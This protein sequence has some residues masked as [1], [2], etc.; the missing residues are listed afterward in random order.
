MPITKTAMEA[1]LRQIIADQSEDP[2]IRELWLFPNER[3]IRLV[4]IDENALPWEHE[5]HAFYFPPGPLS[6][7]EFELGFCLIRP[8]EKAR[9]SP[10]SGWGQWTEGTL[11]WSRS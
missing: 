1:D 5:S 2:G 7:T 9:L 3:Q 6:G 10:P 8:E 11:V 4:A